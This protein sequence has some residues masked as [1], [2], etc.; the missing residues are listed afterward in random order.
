MWRLRSEASWLYSTLPSSLVGRQLT[1]VQ[2]LTATGRGK[3]SS[4][5]LEGTLRS[6]LHL[7]T[8]LTFPT[9]LSMF[10]QLL[11]SPHTHFI[12]VTLQEGRLCCPYCQV[13]TRRDGPVVCQLG[14]VENGTGIHVFF[15]IQSLFLKTLTLALSY[16]FL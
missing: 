4:F 7:C 11:S 10:C 14:S 12:Y 1:L 9:E 2:E 16:V 3:I 15:W 8:H 5:S 6:P 13:R